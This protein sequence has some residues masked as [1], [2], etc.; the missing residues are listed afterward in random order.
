MS[1]ETERFMI[2]ILKKIANSDR[3]TSIPYDILENQNEILIIVQLPGISKDN[4]NIGIYNNKLKINT[5]SFPYYKIENYTKKYIGIDYSD[6]E[7]KIDLPIA[8]TNPDNIKSK[9]KNN[10]MLYIIID[11][12]KET[13][14]N[15]SITPD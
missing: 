13:D 1:E 7:L 10:G 2:E 6:K 11:R 4:L 9:L 14:K 15:F 12:D 3:D 8:L 5:K